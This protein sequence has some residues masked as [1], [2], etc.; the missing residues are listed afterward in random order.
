MKN[1]L[2]IVPKF[3][4]VL[5]LRKFLATRYAEVGAAWHCQQTPDEMRQLGIELM[6]LVDKSGLPAPALH[7]VFKGLA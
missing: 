5:F 7:R 4:L 3:A 1:L 2:R 6:A